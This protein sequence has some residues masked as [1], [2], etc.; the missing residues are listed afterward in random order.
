MTF[1]QLTVVAATGALALTA[2]PM[3]QASPGDRDGD[4]MPDRW[5]RTH[6]LSPRVND[7]A[8]DR[9]RDGLTNLAEYRSGTDPRKADSDHD[10]VSDSREHSGSDG[11]HHDREHHH[12]HDARSDDS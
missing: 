2:V 6:G 11:A 5:E 8:R 1:R 9:D 4:R 3:A 12:D 7:A 10:G